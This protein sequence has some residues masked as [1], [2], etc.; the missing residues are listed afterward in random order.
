MGLL[1]GYVFHRIGKCNKFVALS[2]SLPL[3]GSEG[4]EFE[5]KKVLVDEMACSTE[6]LL[7][8]RTVTS[9]VTRPVPFTSFVVKCV[10]RFLVVFLWGGYHLILSVLPVL[11]LRLPRWAVTTQ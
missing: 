2:S 7:G 11:L 3:L 1:R 10:S 8:I 9:F 4:K 5:A 6:N